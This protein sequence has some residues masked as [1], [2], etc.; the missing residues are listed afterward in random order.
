[1]NEEK[2]EEK[3]VEAEI[4]ESKD[5]VVAEEPTAKPTEKSFPL[6]LFEKKSY[7]GIKGLFGVFFWMSFIYFCY[8]IIHFFIWDIT[9][10]GIV[11]NIFSKPIYLIYHICVFTSMYCVTWAIFDLDSFKDCLVR[12]ILIIASLIYIIS[13]IDIIPDITPIIGQA[14]DLFALILA[15]FN[16]FL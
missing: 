1:M 11:W 5:L 10:W 3:I 12:I 9:F 15:M 4:V 13:P 8:G 14:D 6:C 7:T 2:A 16:S